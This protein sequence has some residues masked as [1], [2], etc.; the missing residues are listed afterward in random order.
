MR[1]CACAP[2]RL[3]AWPPGRLST[4]VLDVGVHR[5]LST[6]STQFFPPFWIILGMK[7]KSGTYFQNDPIYGGW[8]S[9]GTYFQ[10]DPPIGTYFQNDLISRPQNAPPSIGTYFQNDLISRPQND[11]PIRPSKGEDYGRL[12]AQKVLPGRKQMRRGRMSE[13]SAI[14]KQMFQSVFV[15]SFR[16]I[17]ILLSRYI[18]LGA[19]IYT[20]LHVNLNLV[21]CTRS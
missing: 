5:Y 3:A 21:Q 4:L 6:V 12:E 17:S 14:N 13:W 18:P 9:R 15:F 1:L 19:M 7:M 8:A 11:P 16:T 2:G 10:N 20:H